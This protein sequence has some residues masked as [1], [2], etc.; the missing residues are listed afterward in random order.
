M[1]A[2][3]VPEVVGLAHLSQYGYGADVQ[4]RALNTLEQGSARTAERGRV[5]KHQCLEEVEEMATH[6]RAA[7]FSTCSP[8]GPARERQS[9]EL[10]ALSLCLV[11][12]DTNKI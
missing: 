12:L 3:S 7:H 9:P 1:K 5:P 2:S 8:A 4:A 11:V 10:R 6:H